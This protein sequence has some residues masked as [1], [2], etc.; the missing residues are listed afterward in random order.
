MS[1]PIR[2]EG[3]TLEHELTEKGLTL[4]PKEHDEL[5]DGETVYLMS[6][7]TDG[8]GVV[9]QAYKIERVG[10]RLALTPIKDELG[11][12]EVRQ[13]LAKDIASKIMPQI[14]AQ[15]EQTVVNA[16]TQK[17]VE[18]LEA[19]KKE[20]EA[21]KPTKVERRRGCIFLTIGEQQTVL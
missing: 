17:P 13:Q 10:T 14:H 18:K 4:R 7:S 1:E 5:K 8:I 3:T 2:V 11:P 9:R 15:I 20:A 21:A 19:I 16:L 12:E 6:K